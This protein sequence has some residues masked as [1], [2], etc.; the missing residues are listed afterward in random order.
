[1]LRPDDVA[2]AVTFAATRPVHVQVDWLR[3]GPA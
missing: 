1:M 3:L 2:A